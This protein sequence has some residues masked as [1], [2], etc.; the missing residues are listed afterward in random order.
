MS[1]AAIDKKMVQVEALIEKM[2]QAPAIVLVNYR[3]LSVSEVTEL[4][5]QLYESDCELK[6][7]Q[8]NI[9]R[10]AVESLGY[11]DLASDLVGPNAVAFSYSDSV[12]AAKI[13]HEF[14]KDHPALELKMGVVDNE[15]LSVEQMTQLAQIPSREV[16]LTMFAGGIIQPIKEVAI[17]LNMHIEKLESNQ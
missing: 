7:I 12:A 16:L 2:K 13:I 9:T 10:R 6:V 3:G 4:R 11:H 14:A 5:S 1:Q 15:V 17:G 8:N